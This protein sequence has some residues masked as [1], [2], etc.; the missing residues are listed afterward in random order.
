MRGEGL[1]PPTTW[2]ALDED[3]GWGDVGMD[4]QSSTALWHIGASW[5]LASWGDFSFQAAPSKGMRSQS[6][7]PSRARTGSATTMTP[8][9]TGG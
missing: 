3:L 6:K 2:E 9:A 5:C 1:V 4:P 8:S 7:C